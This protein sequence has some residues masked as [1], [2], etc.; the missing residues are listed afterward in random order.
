VSTNAATNTTLKVVN[1]KTLG[2]I[3]VDNSGKVVYLFTKDSK[4]KSTVTGL[5]AALWPPLLVSADTPLTPG[6][7]VAGKLGTLTRANG[8]LQVTYNGIPLYTYSGDLSPGQTNG[9]GILHEWYVVHPNSTTSLLS[10]TVSLTATGTAAA[11]SS[12]TGTGNSSGSG[13]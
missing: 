1:N 9:E 3:L 11:H 12:S 4:N 8:K 2:P 13:W 6:N 10:A 7:G 5:N